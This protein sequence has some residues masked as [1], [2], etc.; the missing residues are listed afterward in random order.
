VDGHGNYIRVLRGL[1]VPEEM[2][3]TAPMPVDDTFDDMRQVRELCVKRNW[4]SVI[5]V[6]SNYHTRRARLTAR[7]MFGPNFQI[8]VVGSKHGGMD[9]S[10]WWKNNADVRTFLIEFEKLVA[11][12]LYIGPRLLVWGDRPNSHQEDSTDRGLAG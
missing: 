6:T 7:Y 10:A 12:T 11:Y 3:V 2:I 9:R 5:I 4:H 1:G 8:A